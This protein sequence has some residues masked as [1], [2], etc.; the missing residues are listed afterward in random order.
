M[1]QLHSESHQISCRADPC[2]ILQVRGCQTMASDTPRA[3]VFAV[4]GL[5]METVVERMFHTE[6]E[7][8]RRWV[9]STAIFFI[10]THFHLHLPSAASFLNEESSS[11]PQFLVASNRVCE[12][13]SAG[14]GAAEGVGQPQS[15][16]EG[17]FHHHHHHYLHL[18][19]H[20]CNFHYKQHEILIAPSP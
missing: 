18:I 10:P 3:G 17:Q 14:R 13:Q 19:L 11:F 9:T 16:Q 4:R 12:G 2:T 20:D 1:Q 15:R 5:H 8:E 6:T 7:E